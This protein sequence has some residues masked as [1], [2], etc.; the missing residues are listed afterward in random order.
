MISFFKKRKL[1]VIILVY[2][3]LLLYIIAALVWWFIALEIQNEQ[4][5]FY[6]S[7]ELK[8]EAPFYQQ[9]IKELYKEKRLK[10]EQY[11]GEG[12]TFL[13][14]ILIGAV[15]VYRATK[16]QINLSR[17]QNNFMT[18]V[19]HELKTPLAIAQL[20]LE[21]L[22]KRKLDE[23]Q[24]QQLIASTLK[25]TKR[26]D[27]LTNNILISSRFEAGSY[28]EKKQEINFSEIIKACL[29]NFADSFSPREI[30][31]NI[32]NNIFVEGE[33]LLLQM[34]VNNVIDNAIKYSPKASL[35]KVELHQSNGSAIFKIIDEGKGIA[36]AE[37]KLIF[38]KFYRSGSEETR[39][40]KGTGLGLYLCKKIAAEHKG[41]IFVSDNKPRGS[42]F[43]FLIKSK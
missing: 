5:F 16:K 28:V 15:F 23:M 26:L 22:Q 6:R 24:Q 12:S 42:I 10:S 3:F 37:K 36:E 41:K 18:A 14:L 29:K 19:T 17:Q 27:L 2:W 21:T 39:T 32:E 11:I 43:T 20:N 35:I 1:A 9:K 30:H 38:E 40:A 34:L 13:L 7:S 33:N 4:M 8:N 31:Q 25:E